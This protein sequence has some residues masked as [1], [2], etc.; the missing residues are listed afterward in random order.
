VIA[1]A[2]A[3]AP[4]RPVAAG[5]G[6]RALAGTGPLVRFI[7]R[8]D[9]VRLPVWIGSL[10]AFTVLTAASL[11]G[12]YADAADRQARAQLIENP[13]IRAF[14]GPGYGLADYTFGAMMAHETLSW[15]AILVALM[16]ILLMVRHTRAEEETGRAELVRSLVV[17]RHAPTVAALLVVSGASVVL[18]VVT[19]VGLAGLGLASIGWAGS[20]LYGAAIA[21][22]G[23][24]FAAVTAVT[25][26]ITEYGRGAGGLAG[27]AFALAYLLR[28]AGDAAQVGGGAL[29]W[30]SPVGWAQQTRV[31]V[32][33]RW[34]PL[35]LAVPLTAG[36]IALG[37][38]LSTRRDVGAGLRPPR[39]GRPGAPASLSGPLGLAWRQHRAGAAWWG[40]A[41]FL[42]GL[43]YGSLVAEVEVFVSELAAMQEWMGEIGGATVIDSFL[44]AIML[45][46]AV[47]VTVFAVLV[48]ARPRAEESAGRA[49]PVLATAVSR[50][51]WLGSHL[52][53][54]LAGGSA[55][56]VLT[57]AGLGLSASVALADGSVLPRVVG[58]GLAYL[59]AV[60]LTVG[61][62][63]A[64]FGLAPRATVLAWLLIGYAG[65]VGMFAGLLDLP[66]WLVELSPFS[67][68]PMLPAEELRWPPLV[69]LT[70]IA[71]GLVAAGLAGFRRRDLE[72]H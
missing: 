15:V 62:A 24:V 69:V 13:G 33:D 59:P 53:I 38:W 54:A 67:H 49:E 12:V 35:L 60:W 9:R 64:L 29:A 18:G 44:S 70:V 48:M 2:T 16:S 20:W 22:I 65:V 52:L 34:W 26:Q 37:L 66:D 72:T 31:Y 3:P 63:A 55:L 30:L 11:P 42:F 58:A 45:L 61:L 41:M 25:A 40:G 10:A 50:T 56:L 7:L 8:R 28:A 4:A 14:T 21:S 68:V 5:A 47:V 51:R 19:A 17:G 32:D 36:L 46:V 39:A 27:A 57:A 6:G 23:V 71:A 1:P 43:G